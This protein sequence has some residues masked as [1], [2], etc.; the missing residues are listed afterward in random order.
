MKA[1]EDASIVDGGVV[2][3]DLILTKYNGVQINAGNVRGPIGPAGPNGV[4]G[5]A[6]PAGP[7]GP[8]GSG[9]P[10]GNW[11]A[12]VLLNSWANYSSMYD[13]AGY[14]LHNNR[15]FIRGFIK[16]GAMDVSLFTLPL[17]FRPPFYLVIPVVTAGGPTRVEVRTNGDIILASGGTNAWVSISNVSFR[18]D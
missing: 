12:P 2:L 13:P 15:V 4:D 18:V 14:Y 16:S 7:A 5:E 1:I 9:E 11:N 10:V 3:D 17:G 8:A 6:G